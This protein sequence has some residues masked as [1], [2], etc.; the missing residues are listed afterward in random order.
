MTEDE[1]QAIRS[2]RYILRE[3]PTVAETLLDLPWLADDITLTESRAIQY[4]AS[5]TKENEGAAAALLAMPWV[6]GGA[7]DVE[8]DTFEW[9][10]WLARN[11]ETASATVFAMPWIQDGITK[12]ERDSLI[13]LSWMAYSDEPVVIAVIAMPWVQDGIAEPEAEAIRYLGTMGREAPASMA[14]LVAMPWVQDSITE[15]EAKAIRYL[16]RIGRID[17]ESMAALVA[18]SWIHD[19]IIKPEASAVQNLRRIGR[20]DPRA[21]AAIIAM[22]FLE[23]FELDD[24][25]AIRGIQDL[26]HKEDDSLL[27]ALMDHPTL[28]D[29]ITDDQTSLVAAAGTFW[30][31]EEL[32]RIL[33][34]GN[35]DIETLSEGTELLPDLK[36]SIVR[37]GS[38]PN[39]RTAEGVKDATEF[40]VEIM[41]LPLPVSR[42]IVVMN[43]KTGNKGYGATNHG[44]AFSF[45]AWVEQRFDPTFLPVIVHEVAHYYWR[46]ME[47][48]IAEGV[49]TTFEYLYGLESEIDHEFLTIP[50]RKDC[51]AHDLKMLSEWNPGTEVKDKFYCNYYL[52]GALFRESLETMGHEDFFAALR[53]LYRLALEARESGGK[54][55]IDEVR[56]AFPGQAEIVEKHWSGKLNAPENR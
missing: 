46:D 12:S 6:Q 45:H 15:P 23:S 4:L 13:G 31:A 52:G 39:P 10:R 50:G 42:V 2:I 36:I 53:E 21:M 28:R 3:Y 5:M 44:Y 14:V 51:E 17:T 37:T 56:Q 29:G 55:G 40:V 34:P 18:M 11:S 38:R 27:S 19:D 25:L 20:E 26:P 22:P 7:T 49:A 1:E 33:N 47:T 41:Q 43:D 9:L 32:R 8:L 35:A 16:E 30:D 54:A 48:W 24:V